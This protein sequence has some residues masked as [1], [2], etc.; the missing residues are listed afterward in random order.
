MT[1]MTTMNDN[2]TLIEAFNHNVNDA[3]ARL[4]LTAGE[5]A[6]LQQADHV[7]QAQL[8]IT[9]DDGSEASYHA[10]RVQHNNARGPYKGGIRYH[11]AADIDEVQGLAA[12][13][14][15]KT[16][17][18]NIPF[19][20]GKGGVQV[21][22]KTLSKAEIDALS[23][24]W[25][26]AF[27]PHI[28]P[29]KDIPAPD[30]YTTPAIMATM[31]DEYEKIVGQHA[32]AVITGKPLA[33]GG[34]AGRG[35]AT[36]QGGAYVLREL[37]QAQGKH[38]RGATVAVQGFGNAGDVLAGLLY[39]SGYRIVAVSDSR[40]GIYHADGMDPEVIAKHKQEGGSVQAATV[41]YPDA[42][43]LTNAE[44]LELPVDVLVPAALDRQITAENAGRIQAKTILELAN[45]PVTPAADSILAERGITVVPDI[46]ANA[47]GVT[48]SYFEWV[49]N[50]SGDQWTEAD[51]FA[52]LE[53]IMVA[54]FADIWQHS[55]ANKVT[56][57][58][59]AFMIALQRIAEA[60]RLRGRM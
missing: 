24:A 38:E 28:G 11:P 29:M 6:A 16:A 50:N 18:V 41:A 17:A 3:A 45:G 37:M 47:G 13:M 2:M 14:A 5:T 26:R 44:L 22:P 7:R 36:A 34:S 12:L 58:Q 59:S 40:G 43:L 56:M 27:A 21:D 20:G 57:R 33:V 39:A 32:P 10:Y 15:L 51:V 9:R 48:V 42:Q 60:M 31:M 25:V 1:D 23:R 4:G 46:L 52:R 49:Q 55:K 8:T 19:G 53:R 54:A 35:T 30:V